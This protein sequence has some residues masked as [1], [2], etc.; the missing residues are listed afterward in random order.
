MALAEEGGED[1]TEVTAEE[2]E[3]V[4]AVVS[5]QEKESIA[6]IYAGLDTTGDDGKPTVEAVLA[7]LSAQ[8]DWAEQ[9][10]EWVE[11]WKEMLGALDAASTLDLDEFLVMRGRS[12]AFAAEEA[13]VEFEGT[14]EEIAAS[15][16][17]QAMHRGR[18]ARKEREGQKD[19]AVKIQAVQRGKKSRKAAATE[20]ELKAHI[21]KAEPKDLLKLIFETIDTDSDGICSAEEISGSQFGTAFASEIGADRFNSLL[22]GKVVPE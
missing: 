3:A 20:K 6:G 5:E 17:I 14:P 1:K 8:P 9:A 2:K 12:L 22:A 19:A 4:D 15:Q 13:G 11:P 7:A 10:P 18:A 21:A 16:K